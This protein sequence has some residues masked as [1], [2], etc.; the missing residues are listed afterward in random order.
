MPIP[1]PPAVL[2]S[3]T[4]NPIH[5]C[6]P[7]ASSGSAR[8]PA[9]GQK[10]HA[11]LLSQFAR[12][13]LEAEGSNLR[14]GRSDKGDSRAFTGLGKR[15][16]LAQKSVPGMHGLGAA[17]PDRGENVFDVQVAFPRGRGA[18]ADTSSAA[19]TCAAWRSAS[20]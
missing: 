15:G 18:D 5:C 9:A 19:K 1:P 12:G 8:R 20:E 6:G 14:A 13:V 17:L 4:G 10:R 11:M 16:I 2:F 7:R 3:I